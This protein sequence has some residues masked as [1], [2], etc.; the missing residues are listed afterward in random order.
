M[1]GSFLKTVKQF[2]ITGKACKITGDL[3]EKAHNN[4]KIF[5]EYPIQTLAL[6]WNYT[7]TLAFSDKNDMQW[8]GFL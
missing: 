1:L 4:P 8:E 7:Q 3:C 6:H 2:V 5:C